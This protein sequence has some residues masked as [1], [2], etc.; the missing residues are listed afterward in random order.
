MVIQKAPR[1][2]Y[3][4]VFCMATPFQTFRASSRECAAFQSLQKHIV[5]FGVAFLFARPKQ[6]SFQCPF[7]H[8]EYY[9]LMLFK[10]I[11]NPVDSYTLLYC[12]ILQASKSLQLPKNLVS[13]LLLCNTNSCTGFIKRKNNGVSSQ[14]YQTRQSS[15]VPKLILIHDHDHT[16]Q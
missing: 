13:V 14:K 9:M 5:T 8:V 6:K 15:E 12:M 4:G 11:V 1:P 7:L 16:Q 10:Y 3:N 2:F